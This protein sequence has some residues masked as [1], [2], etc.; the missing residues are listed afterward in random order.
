M[1]NNSNVFEVNYFDVDGHL[2]RAL[3][4]IST[5]VG[6]D[7]NMPTKSVRLRTTD[8][9]D[10]YE[11]KA[12]IEV[13][14]FALAAGDPYAL[15]RAL[16]DIATGLGVDVHTKRAVRLRT[17]EKG[18]WYEEPE[19]TIAS[20]LIKEEP[21][22]AV[23]V[24]EIREPVKAMEALFQVISDAAWQDGVGLTIRTESDLLM[25]NGLTDSEELVRDVYI[26]I[27]EQL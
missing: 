26:K 10:W 12:A 20:K 6:Y 18:E 24:I 19:S 15:G 2:S 27:K 1:V 13:T 9:G 22:K 21:K 4:D 14:Y 5:G 23:A 25:E 17:N 7:R 11:T 3:I 8:Q 16:I